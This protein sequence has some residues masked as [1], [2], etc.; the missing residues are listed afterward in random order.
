MKI[1]IKKNDAKAIIPQKYSDHAVGYDVSACLSSDMLIEAG[2]V[3]LVPT[4]LSI[5][6]EPGYEVQIRP[7]SGLA[8]KNQICVLNSPGTIDPDYRGE[9]KVILMNLGKEDFVIKHGMRIAQMVVAKYENV[10]FNEVDTLS[11]TVRGDGGFGH[12]KI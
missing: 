7:R 2:K 9:V 3:A 12:T 8:L 4:G 10:H 6:I 5:A 11:E 1:E